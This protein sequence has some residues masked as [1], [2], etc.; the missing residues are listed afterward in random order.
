MANY[1]TEAQKL[2]PPRPK[3]T[4]DEIVEYSFLAEFDLLRH[5][6][7]D[8]RTELWTD[9]SRRE[10]TVK[11]LQL[12]HAKEEIERLNR[13][14]RRLRTSIHDESCEMEASIEHTSHTDRPLAVEMTKQWVL[15]SKV[16]AVNIGYLDRIEAMVGFSGVR[17]VGTRLRADQAQFPRA[18]HVAPAMAL[19]QE[20]TDIGDGA[21]SPMVVPLSDPVVEEVLAEGMSHVGLEDDEVVNELEGMMEFVCNI[22]D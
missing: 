6:R 22:N 8:I 2:R 17:G 21:S 16:N 7:T 14:V 13:E 11:Y 18:S 3:L 4:W 9:P 20:P 19:E 12:Q 5:A 15:H 1:N 10:A